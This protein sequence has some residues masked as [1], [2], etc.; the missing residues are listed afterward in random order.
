MEPSLAERTLGRDQKRSACRF[1]SLGL[2]R[3]G[4][5]LPAPRTI[6]PR[7]LLGLDATVVGGNPV[8]NQIHTHLTD[9]LRDATP[10]P[11]CEPQAQEEHRPQ[12]PVR[13]HFGIEIAKRSRRDAGRDDT[14]QFCTDC[15]VEPRRNLLSHE[16]RFAEDLEQASVLSEAV[17]QDIVSAVE[18]SEGA[19]CRSDGSPQA[20][21]EL[22]LKALDQANVDL[23]LVREVEVERPLR[24]SHPAADCGHGRRLIA[25]LAEH[26][27]RPLQNA[28]QCL[29]PTIGSRQ[30]SIRSRAHW[31]H[32]RPPEPEGPHASG[33]S[34][35]NAPPWV[36]TIPSVHGHGKHALSSIRLDPHRARRLWIGSSEICE[37]HS[38]QIPAVSC[39]PLWLP[40]SRSVTACRQRLAPT[41]SS[42]TWESSS[43]P[44]VA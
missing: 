2:V 3:G 27:L 12:D 16:L 33:S 6:W 14:D 37:P 41:A 28:L 10:S 11:H 21:D 4:R 31:S 22:I 43:P 32:T 1:S 44:A 40:R 23:L 17:Q 13:H 36:S 8:Q 20:S 30:P 38:T 25:P 35:R 42:I 39:L 24:H 19:R 18:T 7:P 34:R 9:I 15:S 5:G 29:P 26:V